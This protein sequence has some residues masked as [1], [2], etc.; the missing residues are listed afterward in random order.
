[1]AL[2][3]RDFKYRLMSEMND[4]QAD[5]VLYKEEAMLAGYKQ[6]SM[7]KRI[8]DLRNETRFL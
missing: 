6:R 4:E 5:L 3:I 8:F 2:T 1:M 7:L